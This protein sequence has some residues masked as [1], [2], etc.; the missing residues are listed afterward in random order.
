VTL[1]KIRFTEDSGWSRFRFTEDS[2][3]SRV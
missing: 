3:W 1:F 2:G